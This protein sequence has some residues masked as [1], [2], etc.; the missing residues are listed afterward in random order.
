LF[1]LSITEH[2]TRFQAAFKRSGFFLFAINE[3]CG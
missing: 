1:L 2:R 3:W